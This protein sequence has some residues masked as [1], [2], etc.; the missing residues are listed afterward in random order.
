V[1]GED[2]GP[3]VVVGDAVQVEQAADLHLFGEALAPFQPRDL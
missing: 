2:G 3:F 1:Q